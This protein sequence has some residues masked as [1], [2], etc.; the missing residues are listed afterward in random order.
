M[1]ETTE[2]CLKT[3]IHQESLGL[4]FHGRLAH[5]RGDAM[6]SCV[7]PLDWRPVNPLIE[8]SLPEEET[9]NGVSC[10]LQELPQM[11][12]F[13]GRSSFSP[14][15]GGGRSRRPPG[16]RGRELFRANSLRSPS[17]YSPSTT[18][19]GTSPHGFLLIPQI[20]MS[21]VSWRGCQKPSS[22]M[23]GQGASAS[24]SW[25]YCLVS[26]RHLIRILR[27]ACFHPR[28]KQFHP[29]L[30]LH[31]AHGSTIYTENRTVKTQ[32]SPIRFIRS[33]I[34]DL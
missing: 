24:I 15:R 21:A 20:L 16:S 7:N 23:T 33:W 2:E 3:Q 5:L 32:V 22:L 8:L 34:I 17:I 18:G 4:G 25:L 14:N 13:H 19:E 11:P 9:M 6:R 12:R 31:L 27:L 26:S 28:R 30:I 29:L 1:Q 10:W